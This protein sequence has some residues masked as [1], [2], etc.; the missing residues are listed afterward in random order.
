MIINLLPW[1]YDH[2]SSVGIRRFIAN[3]DVLNAPHYDKSRMEDDRTAQVAAAICELA[4]AR[5]TGQ[6]WG[7][8]V[9]HASEHHLYKDIIADVGNCIE[10][11]RVRS[12]PAVAVRSSQIGRGLH[13]YAAR[14]IEPEFRS[15]ELL[16]QLPYDAAWELSEPSNFSESTRYV[17]LKEL[18]EV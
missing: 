13:L 3:W 2:A 17:P 16:G 1:E 8:H 7:G 11:R 14:A 18:L 5:H 12:R 9:W 4:V 6:Y 10:V 15:V